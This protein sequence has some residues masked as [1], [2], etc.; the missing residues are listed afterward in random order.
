MGEKINVLIV[1]D[2]MLIGANI[3]LQLK[4]LGYNVSGIIPRGEEALET[5]RNEQPDI[6]LLDINLKG[7]IDGIDTAHLMQKEYDIPIIYLTANADE[8]HFNR[9]KTTNP[10]AFISK[11]FKKMDLQHAIELTISRAIKGHSKR[12]DHELNTSFV[13]DDRIFVKHHDN[14][15][16]IIIKNILYIEADRNYCRIFS[17]EK[18]YLLVMTLKEMVEKLPPEHFLRVH[19]SFIVNI[20][21]IDEVGNTHV[22]VSRRSIPMSKNLRPELFKR[23]QTI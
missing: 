9:A 3:S 22:V 7:D 21:Q 5:I 12:I 18:E 1:E 6:V 15:I 4:Q 13:L 17:K 16:K 2:E 19:R 23:L 10:Y 14:M 8:S 20:S 11:P